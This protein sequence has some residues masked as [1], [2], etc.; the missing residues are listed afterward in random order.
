[1]TDGERTPAI[2]VVVP[3]HDVVEWVDDCLTSMLDDQDVDLEV[4]VVDDDS[5]DGTWERVAA[6]AA[7]DPRVRAFRAPG[8]GGGQA[9]NFGVE[10]A[11][12]EF[13]AFADGDDLV[14]RG[15]YAAMLASARSSGSDM[16]VGDFL[17]FS[18]LATW[19][20]TER[21]TGFADRAQGL[22]LTDR[23]QLVRNRA[24]WNRL[25]RT[26]F[27]REQA[28]A[29]PS[30]PRSNDIVPMVTALVAARTIDVVPDI[31]YL[32]RERPGG[33]SMTAQAGADAAVAS[34]LTQELLCARLLGSL[35][36]DQLAATYWQMVLNADGWVHLRRYARGVQTPGEASAVPHLLTELLSLRR[37]YTFSRLRPE[38]QAVY[39]LGTLGEVD[40]AREVLDAIGDG[41]S[42]PV[43]MDPV[44]A[45]RATQAAAGTGLLDERAQRG[46][47]YAL[48]VE[49]VA[50]RSTPLDQDAADELVALA[51]PHADWFASSVAPVERPQDRLVRAALVSGDTRALRD[52]S[53][54]GEAQVVDAVVV[55]RTS[56]ELEL[57]PRADLAT[58]AS[59][60][61]RA[62][63]PGRPET[64]RSVGRVRQDGDRWRARVGARALPSEGTWALE[65][66]V[67]APDGEVQV[68]LVV[69]R[70]AVRLQGGRL[71][72]LTVRGK[73]TGTVPAT[74]FRRPS[75]VR[76]VVRA[77]RRRR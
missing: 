70:S 2:S 73:G 9:R 58:G 57:R 5:R 48:V 75:V 46:L 11:R 52:A 62:Y 39:A 36:D 43:P 28:I 7:A 25:F 32:Y 55:G 22:S 51:A 35:E 23:P 6:R 34:Y 24:C 45:M 67:T 27:W 31:V 41:G 19:R 12:G 69:Q 60:E 44:R 72:R 10:Q 40:L 56:A 4:I 38:K 50:G 30:V 13:L 77:L 76:R 53:L 17:K 68:P 3:T 33:T 59:L 65:L 18:A 66:L 63:K 15:A 71:G 26:R 14:P 49:N 74:L 16:V 8:V 47:A 1:M 42:D 61:L 54:G 64:Q 37:A 29:Y 21:W 20:P